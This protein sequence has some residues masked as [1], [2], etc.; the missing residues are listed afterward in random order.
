M[1]IINRKICDRCGCCVS[2]CEADCI[3]VYESRIEIDHEKCVS[4][5]KCIWI[6]PLDALEFSSEKRIGE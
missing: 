2:V 4:C 5:R 6:C 3:S 1:I